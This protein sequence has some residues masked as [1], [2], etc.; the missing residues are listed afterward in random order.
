LRAGSEKVDVTFVPLGILVDDN[1][2][3]PEPKAP[4]R[5]GRASLSLQAGK[6]VKTP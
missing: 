6:E 1:P 3:R 4:V 2:S 5:I